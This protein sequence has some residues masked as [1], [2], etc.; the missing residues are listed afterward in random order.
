[1]ETCLEQKTSCHYRAIS[2]SYWSNL[3]FYIYLQFQKQFSLLKERF[4]KKKKSKNS[5]LENMT[6]KYSNKIQDQ[7]VQVDQRGPYLL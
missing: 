1:M 7:V 4:K 5:S 6:E 3:Q 2:R